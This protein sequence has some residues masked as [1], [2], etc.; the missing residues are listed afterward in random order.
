MAANTPALSKSSHAERPKQADLASRASARSRP[1]GAA[2]RGENGRGSSRE[3]G[4]KPKARALSG[5][6]AALIAGSCLVAGIARAQPP[7]APPFS[8]VDSSVS[9]SPHTER[10]PRPWYDHPALFGLSAGYY[11]ALR[12]NHREN[13]AAD[14]RIE[15]RSGL[16]LLPLI[17]PRTFSS[18]DPVFQ[19]RPMAG[20]EGTS[21]DAL[22]AF[23]GLMFD[24]F[25]G[26]HLFISP[27]EAVGLYGRG[28]GKELGSVVEFRSTL[29]VGYRF[30]N[31]V[32]LSVSV[33]HISNA[34]IS[35]YNPGT[36]LLSAYVYFPLDWR[37]T[38]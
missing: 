1:S 29:E 33:G 23:G 5:L 24:L 3:D 2:L 30:D 6:A 18:L 4:A 32:R 36:E 31:A 22:Y 25:L 8:G 10:S 9:A 20:L 26:P 16:S 11:E 7:A 28:N 35:T 17:S 19:I 12:S 34:K 38:R 37:T 15:Y 14:F 21:A 27:S 13:R